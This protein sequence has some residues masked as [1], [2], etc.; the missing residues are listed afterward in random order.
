[1]SDMKVLSLTLQGFFVFEK[2]DLD[3]TLTLTDG[4]DLVTTERSYQKEYTCE[5]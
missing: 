3:M 5:T 1:M 4:L 2:C